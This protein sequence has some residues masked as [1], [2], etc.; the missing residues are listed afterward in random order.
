MGRNRG[1]TRLR[2]ELK[3]GGNGDVDQNMTRSAGK[4]GW[5]KGVGGHRP[6]P[7]QGSP[8]KETKISRSCK[9]KNMSRSQ[10]NKGELKKKRVVKM[11]H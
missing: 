1:G 11:L 10:G 6:L 3:S 5:S 4:D 2:D 7:V 8:R 9:E